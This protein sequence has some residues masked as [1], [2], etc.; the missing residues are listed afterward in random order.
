M[1]APMLRVGC[2]PLS[3]AGYRTQFNLPIPICSL[4]H[5]ARNSR[6]GRGGV[7]E[8]AQLGERQAEPPPGCREPPRLVRRETAGAALTFGRGSVWAPGRGREE[9]YAKGRRAS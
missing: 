2:R 5:A 1:K 6:R 7:I 4:S 3:D 8:G 9:Y